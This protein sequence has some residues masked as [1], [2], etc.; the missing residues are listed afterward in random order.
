MFDPNTPNITYIEKEAV[1][2]S[3][4]LAELLDKSHKAVFNAIKSLVKENAALFIH[5]K[6]ATYTLIGSTARVTSFD[7]TARGVCILTDEW[8]ARSRRMEDALIYCVETLAGGAHYE[9]NEASTP[10]Y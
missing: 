10:Y 1:I 4:H 7:I 8:P 3:R 5:F 2:N 9:V 6:P